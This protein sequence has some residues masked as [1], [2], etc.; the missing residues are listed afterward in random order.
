VTHKCPAVLSGGVRDGAR[1]SKAETESNCL[2]GG[3]KIARERMQDAGVIPKGRPA[4]V[5]ICHPFFEN[6]E[7]VFNAGSMFS[8]ALLAYMEHDG[9][10]A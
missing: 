8:V 1:H 5:K 6:P 9:K 3:I 2:D 7:R 10:R 4:L